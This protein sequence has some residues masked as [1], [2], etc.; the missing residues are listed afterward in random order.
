METD[1]STGRCLILKEV[2]E[3]LSLYHV[4]WLPKY[5]GFETVRRRNLVAL[6]VCEKDMKRKNSR[7]YWQFNEVFQSCASY[8]RKWNF[9][10]YG[11]KQGR[12]WSSRL[13]R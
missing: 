6:K 11:E 1:F 3:L 9:S 4:I 12:G 8:E 2:R 13:G 7:I 10:C 5:Y